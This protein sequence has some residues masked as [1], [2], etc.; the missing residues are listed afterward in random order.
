MPLRLGPILKEF[1]IWRDLQPWCLTFSA[2]FLMKALALSSQIAGTVRTHCM[3]VSRTPVARFSRVCNKC[4]LRN[5]IAAEN[6]SIAGISFPSS[7]FSVTDSVRGTFIKNKIKINENSKQCILCIP[8]TC[9]FHVTM[10][11]VVLF[12]RYMHI[13]LWIFTLL[14]CNSM[15]PVITSYCTTFI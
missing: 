13:K 11:H 9:N 15:Y 6:T 4:S 10:L 12:T 5:L 2:A 1:R 8:A 7:D 3:S 14:F